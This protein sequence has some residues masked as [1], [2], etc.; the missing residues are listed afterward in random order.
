M[1]MSATAARA[2]TIVAATIRPA[3]D[4]VEVRFV[5]RGSGL[6][7][8]LRGE[9]QQLTID[10]ARTLI[11]LESQPL[12]GHELAPV[13][14]VTVA[15][16]GPNS[17]RIVIEVQGRVDYAAVAAGHEL[18]VRFARAGAAPDIAKPIRV[19][20]APV[21]P[22]PVEPNVAGVRL[23]APETVVPASVREAPDG[24][25]SANAPLLVVIDPGHGGR[26]PGTHS[27][28]GV[29]EKDVA[30]QIALRLERVLEASGATVEL[31]R[32][33]DRF[34]TLAERTAIANRDHAALFLSIH[35][36]W[37]SD[38]NTTG[39]ATYY[40]NNTTDRATIRLARMENGTVASASDSAPVNLNYVLTDLRQGYKA[41]EAVALA[42]M[43]ESESVEAVATEGFGLRAAGAMQG[44]FYVLVGA[45][46]PS[47]L[48]ECG[49]LSNAEEAR[50]LSA[51]RYQ[52]ALAEGIGAAVIHYLKDD[53]AV[54]NL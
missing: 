8:H 48:V 43:I 44:P 33:D 27:A 49:F 54:G 38:A 20:V 3:G 35:L 53:E 1:M 10:F 4:Y 19:H 18:I 26:D 40:L 50:R 25:L 36:N 17:A 6:V 2:A 7:W 51:P 42:Q 31:T 47:V 37:S 34:L 23:S 12:V 24:A 41:N 46:M 21:R 22:A 32:S 28:G 15:D 39:I 14:A 29:M 30:L 13:R 9:Q 52:A 5:L 16:P 11:A 45:E